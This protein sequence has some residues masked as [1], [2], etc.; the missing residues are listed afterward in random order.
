MS[1]SYYEDG[2]Y[3]RYQVRVCRHGKKYSKAFNCADGHKK[4]LKKAEQYERKLLSFLD[5]PPLSSAGRKKNFTP[6]ATF[7]CRFE[8]DKR[9]GTVYAVV[10]YRRADGVWK[11]ARK[12]VAKH[13]IEKAVELAQ[14]MARERHVEHPD[15]TPKK[16][17]PSKTKVMLSVR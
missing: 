15:Y 17:M 8:T 11:T 10:S 3:W 12:A 2:N 9:W 5:T 1:I 6:G 7:D 16:K 4:A 13:G 14:Q